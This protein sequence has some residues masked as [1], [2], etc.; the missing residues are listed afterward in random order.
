MTRSVNAS[1]PLPQ[2]DD[3][4]GECLPALA[5]VRAGAS[6]L[7]GEHRIQ[8]QHSTVRP[9][10]QAAMSGRL[11]TEVAL[12]FSVDVDQRRRHLD[13]RRHRETQ[14]LRLPRSVVG[15]LPE[16]HHLDAVEGRAVERVE[17][18]LRRWID[19]LAG[20]QFAAQELAQRLHLLRQ[21]LRQQALPL[22]NRESQG[23]HLRDFGGRRACGAASGS[24]GREALARRSACPLKSGHAGAWPS[25]SRERRFRRRCNRRQGVGM[26]CAR[27]V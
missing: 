13:T 23:S 6:A 24:E 9:R 12:E 27:S 21:Q 17:D 25:I 5:L 4:I 22:G 26:L 8:Q 16:D 15:I 2:G 10:N 18:Q 7:D 19:L 11:D 20:S 14:A 3:P 1:Q